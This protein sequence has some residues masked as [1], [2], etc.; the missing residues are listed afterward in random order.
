M[1]R[2]LKWKQRNEEQRGRGGGNAQDGGATSGES[3][4]RGAAAASRVRGRHRRRA[5]VLPCRLRSEMSRAQ[6]GSASVHHGD[7]GD[8]GQVD[9]RLVALF[10]DGRVGH[11]NGFAGQTVVPEQLLPRRRGQRP[12]AVRWFRTPDSGLGSSTGGKEEDWAAPLSALDTMSKNKVPLDYAVICT[13]GKALT[14]HTA[15]PGGPSTLREDFRKAFDQ[16]TAGV[17][18]F[19]AVMRALMPNVCPIVIGF[20]PQGNWT[21]ET[22]LAC[23]RLAASLWEIARQKDA[24]FIDVEE[25]VRRHYGVTAG[26][27]SE[28]PVARRSGGSFGT[29][30]Q[31]QSAQ[32]PR[33]E[34]VTEV[35]RLLQEIREEMRQELR[36]ELQKVR[37]ELG[38]REPKV[39]PQSPADSPSSRWTA[40]KTD[41]KMDDAAPS[42]ST[43][44]QACGDVPWVSGCVPGQPPPVV[45]SAPLIPEC[46]FR[47]GSD[48]RGLRLNKESYSAIK[49]EILRVISAL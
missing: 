34:V 3:R 35:A 45:L 27:D 17:E 15:Q 14:D 32:P 18:N 48:G 26:T 19:L 16:V 43:S 9:V 49:L 10:G 12:L 29:S 33:G 8:K 37:L 42:Q 30:S 46:A 40:D 1:K 22:V 6:S 28:P 44:A 31:G 13:S 47:P 38:L 39:E 4:P 20:I 24:L 25:V 5:T 23:R 21:P 7:L 41:A 36:Q 11:R 2:W